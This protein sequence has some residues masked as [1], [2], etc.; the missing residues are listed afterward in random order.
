M[1][2]NVVKTPNLMVLKKN[3]MRISSKVN[4]RRLTKRITETNIKS[5]RVAFHI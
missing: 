4:H 5:S 2:V 3:N 1:S